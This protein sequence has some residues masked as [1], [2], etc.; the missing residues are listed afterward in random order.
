MHETE[1][2]EAARETLRALVDATLTAA[3]TACAERGAPVEL[4]LDRVWTYA[5]AQSASCVGSKRTAVS[6]RQRA[7]RVEGGLF[8]HLDAPANKA[9]H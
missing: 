4:I 7:S 1:L 6:M 8:A 2:T 5:A 9:R 3:L